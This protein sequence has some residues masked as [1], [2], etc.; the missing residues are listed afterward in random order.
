MKN[1][2]LTMKNAGLHGLV[3]GWSEMVNGALS[4]N[5]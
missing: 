4:I 5:K 1:G 3:N 2:E